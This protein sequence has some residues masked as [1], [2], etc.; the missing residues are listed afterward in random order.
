MALAHF[1]AAAG[2]VYYFRT[3]GFMSG[4][5][6]LLD[7]DRVDSDQAKYFISSYPLSVS[8]AKP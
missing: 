7:L 1:T 4:N 2:N 8:H 6:L 5:Q 3:R